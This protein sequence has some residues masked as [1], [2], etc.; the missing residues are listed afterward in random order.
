LCGGG[1]FTSDDSSKCEEPQG[2]S[3]IAAIVLFVACPV[4][5]VLG[6]C[7]IM[8]TKHVNAVRNKIA[9]EQSAAVSGVT[10][11]NN[12]VPLLQVYRPGEMEAHVVTAAHPR[13]G[14]GGADEAVFV[15]VVQVGQGGYCGGSGRLQAVEARAVTE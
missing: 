8:A 15:E 9:T 6:C 14:M 5:L 4:L 3:L 11:N 12:P 7:Y 13:E 2:K 10:T 1:Y